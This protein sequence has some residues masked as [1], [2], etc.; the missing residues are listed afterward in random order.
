MC[1]RSV[2]TAAVRKCVR[3]SRS[4]D[5]EI[6]RPKKRKREWRGGKGRKRREEGKR[7]VRE[8]S[9]LLL[10]KRLCHPC[11][12]SSCHA[13]GSF[14]REQRSDHER[15]VQTGRSA[16]TD[17][18]RRPQTDRYRQSDLLDR[19]IV[20]HTCTQN[21]RQR[22]TERWRETGRQRETWIGWRDRDHAIQPGK[23]AQAHKLRGRFRPFL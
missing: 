15:Q 23:I 2:R 20:R 19:Q 5:R 10:Q 13:W 12:G 11:E 7:V 1:T 22:Q 8:E 3:E 4:R 9:D 18:Q 14:C 16:E 21:D 17:T 6:E